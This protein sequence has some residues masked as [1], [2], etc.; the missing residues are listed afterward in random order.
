MQR[1]QQVCLISARTARTVGCCLTGSCDVLMSRICLPALPRLPACCACCCSLSALQQQP[2]DAGGARGA[3]GCCYAGW[4][5]HTT[6]H[7]P[8]AAQRWAA[9]HTWWCSCLSLVSYHHARDVSMART[10]CVIRRCPVACDSLAGATRGG[11]LG[12]TWCSMGFCT[13]LS[14]RHVLYMPAACS[15]FWLQVHLT[16]L[17]GIAGTRMH[18]AAGL[19]GQQEARHCRCC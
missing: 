4:C 8:A 10:L 5:C 6:A 19:A 14:S 18:Q 12:C 17:G 1:A 2:Q 7:T 11:L 9:R 13:A 3:V 16:R 15:C